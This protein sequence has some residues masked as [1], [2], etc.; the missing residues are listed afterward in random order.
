MNQ[1]ILKIAAIPVLLLIGTALVL[2]LRNNAPPSSSGDVAPKAA[3]T[4][5]VPEAPKRSTHISTSGT[6]APPAA[7]APLRDDDPVGDMRLEG[8]VVDPDGHGVDG[9]TIILGSSPPKTATSEEDGSFAFDDL[10]GRRYTVHAR[11]E[12]LVGTPVVV[13]LSK[14]SDPVLLHMKPGGGIEIEVVDEDNQGVSGATVTMSALRSITEQTDA[15][16]KAIIANLPPGQTVI[17]ASA[18]GF[19]TGHSVV[20]VPAAAGVMGEQRISLSKG[21]ALSGTVVDSKGAPVKEARIIARRVGAF[22]HVQDPR[23]EGVTSDAA[24]HFELVA[25]QGSI[26]LL[27]IHEDHA[28]TTSKSIPV[29]DSALSDL[30]ITMRP[31]ATIS[32]VVLTTTGE[33]V[34]WPTVRIVGVAT[35]GGDTN[36]QTV[37][38]QDG[39]FTMTG[40][41]REKLLVH[42]SSEDASSEALEV[43]VSNTAR[44]KDLKV[45]L[46]LSGSL[47]GVVVDED[48]TPVAEAQVRA[49]PDFWEG[50]DMSQ[51]RVQGP[52]F[53]TT[54]GDGTFIIRGL[55]DST[56]QIFASRGLGGAATRGQGIRAS[57]G[58]TNIRVVLASPGS[59]QGVIV[60]SDGNRPE[61]ATVSI[62]WGAPVPVV[63][64]KFNIREVPPGSY[65]LTVRGPRF[66]TTYAPDI[67]VGAGEQVDVGSISVEKGRVLRGVVRDASGSPVAGTNVVMANQ[68]ISDGTSLIPENIGS[69]LDTQSGLRRAVTDTSGQ[70]TLYGIGA[71]KSAIVAD[72]PQGGRSIAQEVPAGKTDLELTLTLLGVGS[73]RGRV[74]IGE[75]PVPNAQI[76]ITA[77]QGAS[78]IVVVKS[79]ERG[80]FY[81]ERVV[82]GEQKVSA[83]L[84]AAAGGS[85]AATMVEVS[86]GSEVQAD[87][88]I[89]Q[90]DIT[91][92][93]NVSGIDDATIDASQVFLFKGTVDVHSGSELNALFLKAA[94]DGKMSFALGKQE[95]KFEKITEG[96]HSVCVIPINGNMNDP[97]FAQKLQRH[98]DQ[99]AVYCQAVAITATPAEQSFGAVVPP[100][101][102]LPE[103]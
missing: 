32:G 71:Q 102:P 42:A 55:A 16:G 91:L 10:V 47:S 44:K 83:M 3:T 80:E 18:P 29:S 78:H 81:A 62:G 39:K 13:T 8:Q 67:L 92:A 100:M 72:A 38:D 86:A 66:A 82:A 75:A 33:A 21:T 20:V 5:Q 48:G 35:E 57:T 51:L 74:R 73:V 69:S 59:I 30:V 25:P 31:S 56:F 64:G 90:G 23:Q 103:D 4:A 70:F 24:G 43:D 34:S 89:D 40:L 93:V 79:D 7:A 84:A 49:T 53:A 54:A 45:V 96:P 36:R 11:S 87:L 6:T 28:P 61:V 15:N 99:I 65:E 94:S 37:G 76:L 101:Q 2:L 95:A 52:G 9:A 50:A 17:S 63:D 14:A 12:N 41:P 98:V 85:M 68:I 26:Q 46:S 27:A 22:V 1:R 88:T 60:L 77:T 19:A 58:D 97:A